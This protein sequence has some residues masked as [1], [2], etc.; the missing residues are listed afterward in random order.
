MECISYEKTAGLTIHDSLDDLDLE[1]NYDCVRE[2]AL[3]CKKMTAAAD[4]YF[5]WHK[6]NP[7][8][9]VYLL[10]KT[11]ILS[12]VLQASRLLGDTAILEKYTELFMEAMQ[13]ISSDQSLLQKYPLHY[14]HSLGLHEK[15]LNGKKSI[16]SADLTHLQTGHLI[17]RWADQDRKDY[18][19][20]M[21]DSL[22]LEI[23]D[24]LIVQGVDAYSIRS[25]ADINPTEMD[26]KDAR[27]DLFDL[28]VRRRKQKLIPV[29]YH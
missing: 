13:M 10:G 9:S 6:Q 22:L 17:G 24:K 28:G 19:R 4:R 21:L 11:G 29:I 2:L 1:N 23:S 8:E 20:L 7:V 26:V 12:I 14:I 16:D 25:E 15:Y 18:R 27:L 5:E 3:V